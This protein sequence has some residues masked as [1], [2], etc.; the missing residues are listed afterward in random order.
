MYGYWLEAEY[1]SGFI[2]QEDEQDR[3]PYI[4]TDNF[5][6]AI[7]RDS[8]TT[9]GHG[10]LVRFSMIPWDD[11]GERHDIDWTTL[12]H[13]EHVRPVYFRR[14][15]RSV[16]VDGSNDSGLICDAHGFGYQYRDASGENVQVVVE[17]TP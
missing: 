16:Q 9:A 11:A 8:A 12:A 14:M 10:A 2:L 1:E 15:R 13:L 5:F 7:R 17:V 3:S 4:A 6:S